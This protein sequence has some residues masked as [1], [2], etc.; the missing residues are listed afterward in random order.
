VLE[1]CERTPDTKV[2]RQILGRTACLECIEKRL[3]AA[4]YDATHDALTG[5]P[6][7]RKLK[8]QFEQLKKAGTPMGVLFIDLTNFKYVNKTNRHTGGD[9]ALRYAAK[10]LQRS[11]RHIQEDG[12]GDFLV[13]RK[14]GD[15]MIV[16]VDLTPRNPANT[17][18]TD[19]MGRLQSAANHVINHYSSR[20]PVMVYNRDV[21]KNLR[22][23]LHMGMAVHEEWM[24]FEDLLEAADPPKDSNA[25]QP[26]DYTEGIRMM[27]D[28]LESEF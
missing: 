28:D 26:I 14:G 18:A 5:L 13:S 4:E 2:P 24:S 20:R 17:E 10:H 21:P 16:L 1:R 7:N 9:I 27:A 25:A 12:H 8:K 23:G 19:K 6:N 11:V 3:H 22:L 15:E